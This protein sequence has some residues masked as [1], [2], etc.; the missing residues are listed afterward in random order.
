MLP[1]ANIVAMRI[2]QTAANSSLHCE[3][4]VLNKLVSVIIKC[5]NIKKGM[6][7]NDESIKQRISNPVRWQKKPHKPRKQPDRILTNIIFACIFFAIISII[8]NII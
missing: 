5:P 8:I 1:L 4:C 2:R 6:A 7:V 3:L